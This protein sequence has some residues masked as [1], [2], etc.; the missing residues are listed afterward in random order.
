MASASSPAV[1]DWSRHPPLHL[2][3]WTHGRLIFVGGSTLR[4]MVT[5]IMLDASGNAAG[6]SCH[7]ELWEDHVACEHRRQRGSE[8]EHVCDQNGPV[9]SRDPQAWVK[10]VPL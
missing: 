7:E 6:R 8:A 3:S 9:G 5:D 1:I 2:A 4:M 10:L